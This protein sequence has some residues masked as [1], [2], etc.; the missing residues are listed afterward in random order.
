MPTGVM[1]R[2]GSSISEQNA[3][4]VAVLLSQRGGI[5]IGHDDLPKLA[6]YLTL[7]CLPVVHA[8]HVARSPCRVQA[9]P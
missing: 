9:R 8:M 6:Q 2:L 7:G 4:M 5:K 1:A 3:L